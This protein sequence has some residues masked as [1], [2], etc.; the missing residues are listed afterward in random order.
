NDLLLESKELDKSNAVEILDETQ[1]T[2]PYPQTFNTQDLSNYKYKYTMNTKFFTPSDEGLMKFK[3]VVTDNAG[4]VSVLERTFYKDITAATVTDFTFTP[5][6]H[7]EG[8]S[9]PVNV[10]TTDYGYYFKESANVTITATDNKHLS[11]NEAVSGLQSITYVAEDVVNGNKIQASD[12]AV[13]G[14]NQITLTIPANFKGQLYAYASD[15]LGQSAVDYASNKHQDAG[16]HLPGEYDSDNENGKGKEIVYKADGPYK[17]YVHPSGSIIENGA[18][19]FETSNILITAPNPVGTEDHSSAYSYNTQMDKDPAYNS[20]QMVPLYNGNVNFELNV[21]DSYSGIREITWTVIEDGQ[22]K[23][24]QTVNVDKNGDLS[25]KND[26]W[27]IRKT[28]HNLV[29]QMNTSVTVSGNYNDMV[30]RVD[31]TD[32]AGNQS[33]DYYMFGI[34]T[35]I[36]TINVT[37]D[38]NNGDS[39]GAKGENHAFY[40]A[41]R[42]ATITVTERNFDP[43]RVNIHATSN[44]GAMPVGLSWSDNIAGGNGDGSTHVAQIVY[45]EDADYTFTMD[46]KDRAEWGNSGIDYGGSLTPENFTVDKTAPVVTVTYDNNNGANGKYFNANRVATITVQEHNFDVNRIKIPITAMLDGQGIAVPG[47]S[48][49]GS[50]DTHYGTVAFN[51]DGDYTLN[52]TEER[53]M[54]G[55]SFA[56]ANYTA[57][58]AQDFTVDTHIVKPVI[59]GVEK[60]HA[61]KDDFEIGFDITDIN[62]DTDKIQLLRTRYD[63]KDEDVTAEFLTHI[64]RTAKGDIAGG[65]TIEKKQEYDG[66]Y[67]LNLAITDKATNKESESITF[68]VNRFGSVYVYDSY[69]T[70]IMNGYVK[71]VDQSLII[72]EYNPDHLLQNSLQIQATRDSSP[73]KKLDYT[74]SPAI[75]KETAVGSS[76]WYEYRY[77]INTENFSKDGIYAMTIASKDEAGNQPENTNYPDKNILFRVD[78]VKP[79]LL[80]VT[81][82][83]KDTINAVETD[84]KYQAFDAIG[85]ADV[86]VYVNDKR[87]K[88]MNTFDDLTSYIGDFTINEGVGQNVKI[89]LKDKAG[90]VMNTAD[91]DFKVDYP[92][93]RIVT[94]STNFFVRWFANMYRTIGTIAVGVAGIGVCVFL[95]VKSGKG[96]KNKDAES[97]K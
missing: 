63:K 17:G 89:V 71:K 6:D 94:V 27:N 88:Y 20:G 19:H 92:F 67:T 77:A 13:D 12:V 58:A 81:G 50:G 15:K 83:E 73:I 57:T 18:Q 52:V 44:G 35:T 59:R 53:D 37:Y 42:I 65:N 91:A 28:E 47:I 46:C 55:N 24:S 31:L 5:T 96:K 90:N 26:G 51:T 82:L 84:V 62:F 61:Y 7:I 1:T 93:E 39:I 9:K 68:S 41:N 60:E 30:I 25:G 66:V 48:W 56:G 64:S 54:A 76:G 36:P 14:K 49:S 97:T 74:V 78:S 45:A 72:T 75:S 85:L 87:V 2:Y 21:E 34:D 33:Y 4:N 11:N 43:A 10:E 16:L 32:R 69:L 3:V 86:S 8:T 40:N 95:L 23:S 29:T 79:E 22:D 70:S 38:N 80:S